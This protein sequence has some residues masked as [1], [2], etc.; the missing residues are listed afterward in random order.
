MELVATK[1]SQLAATVMLYQALGGGWRTT[2]QA[3]D[4]EPMGAVP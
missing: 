2:E 4:P 1:Q 3:A